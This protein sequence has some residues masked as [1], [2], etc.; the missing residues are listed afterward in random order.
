ML[1]QSTQLKCNNKVVYEQLDLVVWNDKVVILEVVDSSLWEI[2]NVYKLHEK[3]F[4]L[5]LRLQGKVMVVMMAAGS[6]KA[7]LCN[8]NLHFAPSVSYGQ[9]QGKLLII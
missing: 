9:L 3:R 2:C 1:R 4:L 8:N 5:C 7:V 6:T